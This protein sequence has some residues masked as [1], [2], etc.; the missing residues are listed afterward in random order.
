MC[1]TPFI[2]VAKL[3]FGTRQMAFDCPATDVEDT[4]N[5]VIREF[6]QIPQH[7]EF[8]F[9]DAEPMERLPYAASAEFLTDEVLR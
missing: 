2:G 5:L 7:E 9:I 4:G 3:G 8:P 6:L 1:V